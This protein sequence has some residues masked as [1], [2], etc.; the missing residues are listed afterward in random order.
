M[1][2]TEVHAYNNTNFALLSL[3][4][5]QKNQPYG[6]LIRKE[7][8]NILKQSKYEVPLM[9]VKCVNLEEQIVMPTKEACMEMYTYLLWFSHVIVPYCPLSL[10]DSADHSM[11]ILGLSYVSSA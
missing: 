7:L 3:L 11:R 4:R 9:F 1:Q 2:M 8:S 5:F 10:T 6:N